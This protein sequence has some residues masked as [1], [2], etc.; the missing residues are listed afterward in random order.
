MQTLYFAGGCLWG[1]QEFM[2]HLPG[3]I[4]TEAG[5]ANGKTNTTKGPYD[6]YAE[7]VKVTFTTEQVSLYQLLSYFFEIIDP[8]SLNQQGEDIG[9]KYRTG[10]YSQDPDHL[11]IARDFI[12]VQKDAPRIKVEVMPLKN[13]V[14]SDDEHQD[15][16]TRFPNDYCHIPQALLNKFK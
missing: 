16:L 13:Y 4:S 10:I 9:P 5:R 11:A 7:C 12:N 2:K 15:R 6:G 14:K 3:V 8:Y 1:V